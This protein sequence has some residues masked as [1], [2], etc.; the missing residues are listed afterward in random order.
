MANEDVTVSWRRLQRDILEPLNRRANLCQTDMRGRYNGR[1]HQNH[2]PVHAVW[3][4]GP[5]RDVGLSDDTIVP[6]EIGR[7]AALPADRQRENRPAWL[8]WRI[9]KTVEMHRQ[10][11]WCHRWTR[12]QE[13]QP[14]R[15]EVMGYRAL[16][17]LPVYR[18]LERRSAMSVMMVGKCCTRP[19]KSQQ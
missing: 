8:E 15:G 12:A 3:S 6:D 19:A 7:A 1:W 5:N 9:R 14:K 17:S 16:A 18:S 2:G 13:Q 10:C 11:G 4:H